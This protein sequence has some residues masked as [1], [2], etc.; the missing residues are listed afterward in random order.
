MPGTAIL[1]RKYQLA[2]GVQLL[3]NG[4]A[5]HE[6]RAAVIGLIDIFYDELFP[7]L[8]KNLF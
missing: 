1:T 3:L 8:G 4:Y 2:L 6:D 7:V 5:T